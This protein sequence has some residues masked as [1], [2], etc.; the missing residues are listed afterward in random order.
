[1]FQRIVESKK[2]NQIEIH[3]LENGNI[4]SGFRIDLLD[5]ESRSAHELEIMLLS[6]LKD[7][8]QNRILRFYL[9]AEY[10]DQ[11]RFAHSRG[12]A[13]RRIGFVKYSAFVILER[14]IKSDFTIFGKSQTNIN[15]TI[16]SEFGAFKDSGLNVT[17]LTASQIESILPSIPNELNH[18]FQTIDLGEEV[19][20]VLRL[21][22]Q[23]EFGMDFEVLSEMKDSLPL[24]FLIC[25]NV[26]AVS[27]SLSETML[28]R[29]SKQN[30]EVQDIKESRKFAEAQSDL[31]D[32]SLNG[33]K[34]FKFEWICIVQRLSE[35]V[36]RSDR[37]EIKRKLEVLGEVYIESVGA[38]ESLKGIYPGELPH[39]SLFERDDVLATYLPLITRGEAR[40][41]TKVAACSMA[42]HRKDESISFI[43]FF[44]PAYES[45]SWC[46][47]GRPGTGKSVITNAITRSLMNDPQVKIIKI[48]VGG[49]HS[50]ETSMLKG[51]EVTLNLN[52]PTGLNPFEVILELGHT[53]ESI[54]ILASFIEVLILEEGETKLPK[55]M[56]S[57][58]ERSLN[59]FAES[60]L[61]NHS[62][63]AYF[64]FAQSIPRRELLQRWV[65]KGVY[66][67]AFS[68]PE[69]LK[70]R[71]ELE[72]Q[73]IY[74]NFSKISQALDPDYAQGGLAAVMAKFNL[75]MLKKEKHGKRIVFIADET[76]FFIRKCF[77]FF[78]LSIANVR[79]EGHGFITIA[80]KSSHVVIG[81][82]TGILD[83]SPNKIFFSLDGDEE[84]F[85]G[86]TQLDQASIEKIK[87][88][89]RKQGQYSE[90]LLKDQHGERIIRIRLSPEEYWAYTSKDEDKRK[91]EQI[92]KACP[93]LKL[94]EI[95]QCLAL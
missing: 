20:S 4:I 7:L 55:S 47:F 5:F 77:S 42:V 23:S 39:Y 3:N 21:V 10:S 91:I 62:L 36:L 49:S 35:T 53:R 57:E 44:D 50:R 41:V 68:V 90:A 73:L 63:E 16:I 22:K 18:S 2:D 51:K 78:N 92:S 24:P 75:E 83:N 48:D 38:L 93:D 71:I 17:A 69:T 95:I 43:D 40:D 56:K 59:E 25:C 72:N 89:Q 94:E 86:R 9:K 31:E 67:N 28:R 79:K 58:L 27:Q 81:G 13:L 6:L 33:R 65:G 15:Q 88:L 11:T 1:M 32:V 76:P 19:L 64:K 66:G 26:E 80:Q 85:M 14:P 84:T 29:R 70:N 54:Q 87:G 60:V 8:A 12:E 61:E 46:I 52:E 82:N 45:F 34:L 30:S 74:F 37:E